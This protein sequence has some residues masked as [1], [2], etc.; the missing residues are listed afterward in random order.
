MKKVIFIAPVLFAMNSFSQNLILLN[1]SGNQAVQAQ[2]IQVF[3]SNI[4]MNDNNINRSSNSNKPLRA[5]ANP[6]V[7]SQRASIAN[8]NQRR[9]I[10]RRVTHISNTNIPNP[11]QVNSV[12]I[13][14]TINDDIQLQGNFSQ[15]INDNSGN[16]FGNE[17]RIEQIASANIPAIQLGTGSLDL[18]IDMPTIKL[19]SIKFTSRK[20]VSGS[21]HKT[22]RFRNKMAK[23]NRQMTGKFAFGKKLKI[24]VDNCFKW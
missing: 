5:N 24:K 15:Q 18:N 20:S 22:F 17:N 8:T 11:V 19:P 14:N 3:A 12:N 23:M 7:Q 2:S 10:R 16:A 6:Q 13:L 1:N 21:K 9:Q 4:M